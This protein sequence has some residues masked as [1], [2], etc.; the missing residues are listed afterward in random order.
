[1]RKSVTVCATSCVAAFFLPCIFVC[2]R[3]MK[4][5][6]L[7]YLSSVYFVNQPLHVS[8]IF[9]THHREVYCAYTTI[10]TCCAFHLTVFRVGMELHPNSADNQLKRTT[11]TNCCIFTAYLLIYIKEFIALISII[12]SC[13][14]TKLFLYDNQFTTVL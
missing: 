11:R 12:H 6:L 5:N 8:G 14:V 13:K 2:F 7:H 1:M 9:V 4:T 10:G 3:V